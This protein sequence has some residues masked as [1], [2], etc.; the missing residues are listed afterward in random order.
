M[1]YDNFKF[2]KYCYSLFLGV[3][4]ASCQLENNGFNDADNALNKWAEA[5][6]NFDYKEAMGYMTPESAK[7]IRFAASN[8]TEKDVEFIR[9]QDKNTVIH[10]TDRQDVVNDTLYNAT[11]HVSNFIQL[12]IGEGNNQMIDEADFDIQMVKRDGEWLVRMEGLPRSGKQS[13]D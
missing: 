9:S 10:I 2:M 13:R 11:I 6:F 5:Y 8:I 1:F 7:W 12:G 3:L 4:L